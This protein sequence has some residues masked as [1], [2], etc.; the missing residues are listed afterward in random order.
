VPEA[1]EH[2]TAPVTGVQWH[3]EDADAE[4]DQLPA[5]LAALADACARREPDRGR[6]AA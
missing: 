3:P 2:A 5:L 4:R 6:V 1:V